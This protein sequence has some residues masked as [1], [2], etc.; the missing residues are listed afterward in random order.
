MENQINVFTRRDLIRKLDK[1]ENDF[2]ALAES[3]HEALISINRFSKHA[4]QLESLTREIEKVPELRD[5]LADLDFVK[6]M[7]QTDWV[8]DEGAVSKIYKL[9]SEIHR[10][11]N[12]VRLSNLK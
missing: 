3:V 6:N 4:R 1:I 7:W 10:L 8:Y 12:D 2:C 5:Q 9:R 11:S